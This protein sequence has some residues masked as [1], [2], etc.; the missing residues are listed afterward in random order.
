MKPQFLSIWYFQLFLATLTHL[1]LFALLYFVRVLM[2][3]EIL[4]T[5]PQI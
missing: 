3:N 1:H 5:L 4:D 2:I